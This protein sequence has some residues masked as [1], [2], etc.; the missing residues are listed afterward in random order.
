MTKKFSQ[1]LAEIFFV[2]FKEDL[3]NNLLNTRKHLF[4][5]LCKVGFI[6]D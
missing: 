1:F 4:M 6:V 2:E 5:A 3:W